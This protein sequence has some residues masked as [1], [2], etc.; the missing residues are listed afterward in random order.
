MTGEVLGH[1][2]CDRRGPSVLSVLGEQSYILV[3]PGSS[4]VFEWPASSSGWPPGS[5]WPSSSGWL[6]GRIGGWGRTV[7]SGLDDIKE[8]LWKR[9][10]CE[11]EGKPIAGS[12]GGSLSPAAVRILGETLVDTKESKEPKETASFSRAYG[13]GHRLSQE[14]KVKSQLLEDFYLTLSTLS[15]LGRVWDK[16]LFWSRSE[17]MFFFALSTCASLGLLLSVPSL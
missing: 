8:R 17:I 6:P 12:D 7:S 1:R 9:R 10:G 16:A 5:G 11:S 3:C 14:W 15:S 13:S 4:G 2:S